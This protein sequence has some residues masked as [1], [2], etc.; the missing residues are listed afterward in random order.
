MA[1]VELLSGAA[2]DTAMGGV[3][4]ARKYL[5]ASPS[6]RMLKLLH[7]DFGER[8]QLSMHAFYG[9]CKQPEL[10]GLIDGL[11]SGTV[12]PDD[13]TREALKREVE[14]CLAHTP[15]GG[16]REALAGEI[17]QA[18][19][20][21]YVLTQRD[22]GDYGQLLVRKMDVLLER[23]APENDELRA[24]LGSGPQNTIAGALLT[25]PLRHA[26]QQERVERAER[27]EE[28][29]QPLAAA[30]LLLDAA[31]GLHE[32][33]LEAV[34]E[35]YR[36]RAAQLLGDNGRPA[37]AAELIEA[38]AWA[39]I[40]RRSSIA[41]IAIHQLERLVGDTPRVRGLRA[42]GQFPDMAW[43][44]AWLEEALAAEDD[45]DRELRFRAAL[46][47]M[48]LLNGDMQKTI[49]LDAEV[50]LPFQDGSRLDLSLNAIDALDRQGDTA[51]ADARW[52]ELSAWASTTRASPGGRA[53]CWAR[54]GYLLALR[55]DVAGSTEAY[56]HA[57]DAWATVPNSDGQVADALFS[58]Q[59]AQNMMGVWD[60]SDLHLR[61]IA[62]EIRA[63]PGTPVQR[64]ERLQH[65]ATAS[66]IAGQLPDAHRDYWLALMEYTDMGSL[67][68]VLEVA[69]Q[70][71]ELYAIT[72][73]GVAAISLYCVGGRAKE[74]SKLAEQLPPIEAAAALAVGGAPWQRTATY[75]VLSA[76]N[77]A[78][79]ADV[80][81]AFAD[82]ILTDVNDNLP[83]LASAARRALANVLLQ[84]P[85]E[86]CDEALEQVSLD[87]DND[88]LLEVGRAAVIALMRVTQLGIADRA[89]ALIDSYLAGR[90]L[91]DIPA[92]WIP[93]LIRDRPA[94]RERVLQAARD[95]QANALEV[96]VFAD[97]DVDN[98]VELQAA[99]TERARAWADVRTR[100]VVAQDDGTSQV[101]T[102]FGGDLGR[103]G[104][105]GRHA[106]ETVREAV[107][108][109]MAE[110]VLDEEDAESNRATA[111]DALFNMAEVLKADRRVALAPSL[112]L[113]AAGEYQ[114]PDWETDQADPLSNFQF[115]HNVRDM[116][117]ASAIRLLA[118][119]EQLGMHVDGFEEIV[120][121]AWASGSP[122]PII[123]AV[124]ALARV[125]G[126]PAPVGLRAMLEHGD[127][128]VRRETIKALHAREPEY[129]TAELP[130]L[131]RDGS[132]NVRMLAL[133]IAEEQDNRVL[134]SQVAAGD[135]DAYLRGLANRA[136]GEP[137]GARST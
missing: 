64:A 109:R 112:L 41:S 90:P 82:Q 89:E 95:G 87:L 78:A 17:A 26:E 80:V 45:R 55:G 65:N 36:M 133:G 19:I 51:A 73:R 18:V 94:L 35:T 107:I 97:I 16:E 43:S 114:R 12:Q 67:Q 4:A 1:I 86:R 34:S 27:L 106:E 83:S 9:W 124:D 20:A 130:K 68:G 123:A 117:R 74:A 24:V 81:A 108:Q 57:M 75:D 39:Q 98:D 72:G 125:P 3:V 28:D 92:H 8:S 14:P 128:Q 122:R 40:D 70:L 56:R 115:T 118:R 134:L 33:G 119:L 29:G 113:L 71:A 102:S 101:Q 59:S 42:C 53:R 11:T 7:R 46:S 111:T 100:E 13:Q 127:H 5:Q 2:L 84:F 49:D 135:P 58:L 54:R 103:A 126:L 137:A 6:E 91:N 30:E 69:P 47:R 22:F 129:L 50:E 116:L 48:E 131:L 76:I 38:V 132:F 88:H 120:S 121:A 44:N 104:L 110:I 66:R 31:D 15:E 62:A 85:D 77:T 96:L 21:G 61:P 52:Q 37:D 23:T 105:V 25:G 79:P 10:I 60:V 63:Q 99:A 32:K 136:L 93:D